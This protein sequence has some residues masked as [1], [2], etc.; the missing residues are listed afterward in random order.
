M[1]KMKF[2]IALILL[3][4]ITFSGNAQ[5]SRN[6]EINQ[7]A[8]VKQEKQIIINANPEKVWEILTNIEKWSDWNSM[9]KST[10]LEGSL[11]QGEKFVWHINGAKIKSTI[12]LINKNEVFGWTGK[13][14][15]GT[16]IHI[17]YLEKTESGTL[18]KVK[19]SMQGWLIRLFK[20]K[21]NKDLE[22][23]MEKWLK[24][25]KNQCEKE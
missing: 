21:A 16:A 5:N 1:N 6:M 23:D 24:E 20:R 14:F 11:E 3:I 12:Q 7:N 22:R 8:P 15:G 25:L 9:I 10:Q 13:T 17:W 4:T 2:L 19:E 18:L